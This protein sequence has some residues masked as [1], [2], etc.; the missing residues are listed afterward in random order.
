MEEEF[1]VKPLKLEEVKKAAREVL[2][3]KKEVIAAYIYGSY[4]QSSFFE[5]VDIGLL[6]EKDFK[7]PSL[8]EARIAGELERKLGKRINFD[9]RILNERP[10]RFLFTILK[11]S[12]LIYSR[13]E[14]KRVE[15]ES[16]VMKKYLDLK[17]H[18]ELYERMRRRRYEEI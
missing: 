17:P 18:H 6:V 1:R 9:V 5:D 11:S 7:P 3:G 15:F 14:R 10:V 13:D 8:Y 4:L 2:S 16:M 12:E